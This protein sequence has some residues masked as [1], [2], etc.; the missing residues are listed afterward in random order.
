METSLDM[1]SHFVYYVK[2]PEKVDQTVNKN[3]YIYILQRDTNGDLDMKSKL[4]NKESLDCALFCCK[5][6]R[7]RR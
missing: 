4:I 1:N 6:R 3:I 2:D 5:A 7:K